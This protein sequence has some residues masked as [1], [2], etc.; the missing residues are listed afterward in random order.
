M[1]IGELARRAGV[2]PHTI[3]YY[4]RIG[5]MPRAGR[6]AGGRRDYDGSALV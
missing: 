6:D 4:E 5:L 3:R 1:K 2:S